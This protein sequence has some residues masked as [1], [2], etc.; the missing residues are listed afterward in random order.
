MRRLLTALVGVAVLLTA[1]P[2]Q[3]APA[4]PATALRGQLVAGR[5]VGFTDIAK[6]VDVDG[7]RVVSR[8]TGTFQF[9]AA[10]VVASDATGRLASWMTV[11]DDPV[12]GM[13]DPERVIRVKNTS[14]G[15]G[16][17]IGPLLPYGKNWLKL[18]FGRM[19]LGTSGLLGQIIN[20]NE[21][22]T[23]QA[24]LAK[25][26]RRGDVYSGTI[27][28]TEL[29]KV[30]PWFRASLWTKP[31]QKAQVAWR[32]QVDGTRLAKR[33]TTSYPGHVIGFSSDIAVDT[34]FTGW[35]TKVSI[36]APPA[37]EV[38]TRADVKNGMTPDLP[39]LNGADK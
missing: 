37:E 34:R 9:G 15:S 36:K 16:G 3:A 5:G 19:A 30:S 27:T 12:E 38:A 4:D 14:Y 31:W 10:G 29:Y 33:L 20:V 39:M 7:R 6:V 13:G 11:V 25:A 2:A 22:A 26:K 8:R 24:L 18:D 35:G 32:L 21:P 23:L 28:V 1:A 17:I